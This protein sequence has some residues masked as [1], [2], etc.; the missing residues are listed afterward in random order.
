MASRRG[1][2]RFDRDP[3]ALLGVGRAAGPAELR[4]AFRTL[5]LRHHPDRAGVASTEVFQRISEAYAVLSDP[6]QRA[7][8][9]DGCAVPDRSHGTAHSAPPSGPGTPSGSETGQYDG[10]GGR[11]G[12]RRARARATPAG[13]WL[14]HLSG[15]LD[16]LLA[17]GQAL[18]GRDGVV[19][20]AIDAAVAASGGHATIDAAVA[21]TC[22]T[23]AGHA[24]PRVLWCRRCEYA[25][26][27]IDQVTF[28]LELPAPVRPGSTFTFVTDPTGNTAPF[29]VRIRLA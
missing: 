3:Y 23:C 4:R 19:E 16:A 6:Q 20:L 27:V 2:A 12:W 8:Y 5:A 15:A 1:P 13:P 17:R 18:R 10:P 9:D 22:P 21:I 24:E 26:T 28:T 11:I 29:R 25:G 14:E 7:R